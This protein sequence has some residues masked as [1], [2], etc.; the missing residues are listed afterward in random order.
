MVSEPLS[1]QQ[2]SI[3]AKFGRGWLTALLF[4]SLIGNVFFLGLFGARLMNLHEWFERRPAYVQQ[5]GPMAG[6]ALQHLL[7]PL[8]ES[9]RQIV[10]GSVNA[11]LAELQ[12]INQSIREQRKVVA[13]LLKADNYDRKAVDEAFAELRRRTDVMQTALQ[14][15]LSEAVEKLS[16]AARKQLED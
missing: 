11:H 10:V 5:L 6:Y 16:P 9:D 7:S 8:N 4:V 1:G 2:K 13:Q 12:Q 15:A 3:E 14:Q